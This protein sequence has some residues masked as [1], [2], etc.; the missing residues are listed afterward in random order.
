[1]KAFRFPL[2]RALR[3]RRAQFEIE[4]AKLQRFTR[5]R[6]QVE[7][8]ARRIQME[9]ANTRRTIASQPL[10]V[11]GEIS[12]M[13]DYQHGIKQGLLKLDRQCQELIK[14]VQ[15]Q[16]RQ[17]VEAERK[18]KLL[19]KHRAKRFT[20]WETEMAKEQETFAAEAYLARW[21]FSS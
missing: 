5:D 7:V 16:Q 15:E 12:T 19:E 13:P 4:L 1:M 20:E 17:T 2:D 21:T 3:I 11:P 10:I 9:A 14:R 8:Q 6:E 18:V